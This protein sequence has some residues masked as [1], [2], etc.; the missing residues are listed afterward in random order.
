M[1]RRAV[2]RLRALLLL[3]VGLLP[4]SPVKNRLF[5]ALGHQIDA[6][7]R[8]APVLL[9]RLGRMQVGANTRI[10][11]LNVFRGMHR[12]EIGP[13]SSI[14][15][16]NDFR[17]NAKYRRLAD[18]PELAGV[19]RAGRFVF[20]SKRHTFDCSGG[21]VMGDRSA[22]GGRQVFVYSHS[23]DPREDL[24]MCEP[25]RIGFNAMVASKTTLAMGATLPDR[26]IL[27]M[28]ATL[29]PGATRPDTMYA[30]LPARPL[31]ID[32]SAWKVFTRPKLTAPRASRPRSATSGDSPLG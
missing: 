21:V 18:Q 27:A 29:L 24:L 25:T 9:L 10:G 7:A 23:Y 19:F 6:T 12:V 15:T 17:A 28:G 31:D 20:I 16:A 8:I 32:I 22:I 5:N 4:A 11:P 1:R 3:V 2:R 13:D 26:S 30:G 14:G